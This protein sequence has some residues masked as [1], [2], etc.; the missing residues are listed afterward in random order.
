MVTGRFGQSCVAADAATKLAA[1]EVAAAR[2]TMRSAI[3]G[4]PKLVWNRQF[5]PDFASW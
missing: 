1:S 3:I 5:S 4:E 2:I